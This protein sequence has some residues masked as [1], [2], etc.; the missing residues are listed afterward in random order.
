LRNSAA[1]LSCI[2]T[3]LVATA[4]AAADPPSK[5][6][7]T[8]S[9]SAPAATSTAPKSGAAPAVP[10]TLDNTAPGS[11]T[12]I[13]EMG[14]RP[15]PEVKKP[16][17]PE[18]LID[19][20]NASVAE[21]KTLPGVGD[22]EAQKIIAARPFKSKAE[23]VTKAGLADGIYIGARHKVEL[24]TMKKSSQPPAAKASDK[25]PAAA[26]AEPQKTDAKP[27]ESKQPAPKAPESQK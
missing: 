12:P 27:A 14:Q 16:K 8:S 6:S 18:K 15:K 9:T 4:V 5:S 24:R 19:L 2:G 20:N 22:V 11:G 13:P 7:T 1:V 10:P 26:K 25:K 17:A 23:L 21:L 3:L